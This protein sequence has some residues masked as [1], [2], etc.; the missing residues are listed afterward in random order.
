ME[1]TRRACCPMVLN[2]QEVH[3]TINTRRRRQNISQVRKHARKN[4]EK[5]LPSGPSPLTSALSFVPRLHRHH[6]KK[7]HHFA[8]HALAIL[9]QTR[10]AGREVGE[11]RR[12]STCTLTWDRAR[13]RVRSKRKDLRWW[14]PLISTAPIPSRTV[15]GVCHK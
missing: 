1:A 6:S 14:R 15:I 5:S 11:G 2:R 13:W 10:N 8:H 12:P 7:R 4:P 9:H 3:F